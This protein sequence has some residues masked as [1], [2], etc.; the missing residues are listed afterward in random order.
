[1]KGKG[2]GW[3]EGG[4]RGRWLKGQGGRGRWGG[5]KGRLKREEERVGSRGDEGEGERGRDEA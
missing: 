3:T 1:M 5:R 2:K 4:G